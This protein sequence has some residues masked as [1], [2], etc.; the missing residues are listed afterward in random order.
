MAHC[1]AGRGN[2]RVWCGQAA[3]QGTCRPGVGS[4]RRQTG[5]RMGEQAPMCGDVRPAVRTGARRRGR[6]SA[7]WQ[8]VGTRCARCAGKLRQA[9]RLGSARTHRQADDCR[10]RPRLGGWLR[11]LKH[12]T[13]AGHVMGRFKAGNRPS[14]WQ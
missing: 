14:T 13:C 1:W 10:Q 4:Q 6:L 3:R 2:G 11:M 12:K 8:T 5:A 9:G 7:G